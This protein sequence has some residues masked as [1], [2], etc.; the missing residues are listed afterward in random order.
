MVKEVSVH[1]DLKVGH[2]V[3]AVYDDQWYLGELFVIIGNAL[4]FPIMEGHGASY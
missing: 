1:E 3:T 2:F 4:L